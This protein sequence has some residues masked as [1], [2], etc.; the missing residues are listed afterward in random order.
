VGSYLPGKRR[1][2]YAVL[3]SG[4]NKIVTEFK[5]GLKTIWQDLLGV[6]HVS[7]ADNFFELGGHSLLAA[8]LIN[9]IVSL[10]GVKLP[11][12]LLFASPTFGEF[13]SAAQALVEA[14]A[15]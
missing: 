13:T 9:A 6:P 1:G 4:G 12:R 7:D 5:E 10:H 2:V 3:V 8:R 14:T 11:V 15:K